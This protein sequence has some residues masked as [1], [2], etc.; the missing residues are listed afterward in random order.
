MGKQERSSSELGVDVARLLFLR[1][2]QKEASIVLKDL[3]ECVLGAWSRPL[4]PAGLNRLQSPVTRRSVR[5][6]WE[7]GELDRGRTSPTANDALGAWAVRW[8][9][10]TPWAVEAGWEACVFWLKHP[11]TLRTGP[12]EWSPATM[13]K[14]TPVPAEDRALDG[15]DPSLESE[16]AFRDRIE[17]HI[18]RVKDYAVGQGWRAALEDRDEWRFDWVVWYQVLGLGWAEISLKDT[19]TPARETVKSSVARIAGLLGLCL[20]PPQDD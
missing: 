9:L 6:L 2:I 1:S 18:V 11:E 16:Q 10:S 14:L 8:N 7:V 12:L 15:W 17:Q 3:R 20:R 13:A 5:S 4:A 19:E